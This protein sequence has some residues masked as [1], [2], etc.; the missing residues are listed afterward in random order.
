VRYRG[1]RLRSSSAATHSSTAETIRRNCGATRKMPAIT[2]SVILAADDGV[3]SYGNSI[4]DAG[5]S[6]IWKTPSK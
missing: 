4:P 1:G 6:A 3:I 5:Q 2:L